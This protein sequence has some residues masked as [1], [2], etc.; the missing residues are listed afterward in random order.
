M[1]FHIDYNNSYNN[2]INYNNVPACNYM[3]NVSNRNNTNSR[4][5]CEICSKLTK[6]N[7]VN[8][9]HVIACWGNADEKEHLN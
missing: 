5:R 1:I 3:F 8:F 4:T 9:E 7:I 2:S 6:K